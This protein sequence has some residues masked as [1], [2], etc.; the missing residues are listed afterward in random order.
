MVSE[1]MET[2]D[3]LKRPG[4]LLITP[5]GKIFMDGDE[6]LMKLPRV[7]FGSRIVFTIQR[8]DDETLRINVESGDKV[9]TYDWTVRTP[10]HFAARFRDSKKWNFM[11]K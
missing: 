11:V 8:K 9:V 6:K 7:R 3:T 2:D 4:S 5:Q 1:N 10:L